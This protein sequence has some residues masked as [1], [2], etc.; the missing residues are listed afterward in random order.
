[1]PP[2]HQPIFAT[3]TCDNPRYSPTRRTFRRHPHQS[4]T[5]HNIPTSCRAWTRHWPSLA[6]P[7]KW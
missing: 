2:F 6:R 5:P 1:M 3:L 4:G 7:A